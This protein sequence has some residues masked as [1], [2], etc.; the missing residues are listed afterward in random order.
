MPD[1]CEANAI[2]ILLPCNNKLHVKSPMET[3]QHK[4]GFST[5]YSK[6]DNFNLMQTLNLSSLTEDKFQDFAHKILA[7]KQMSVY[8]NSTLT[9]LGAYPTNFWS[10]VSERILNHK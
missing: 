10:S 1:G 9:K 6:I 3:P 7:M 8:V 2:S 5:S 4:L